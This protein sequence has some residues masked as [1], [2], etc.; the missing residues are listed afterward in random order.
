MPTVT[1]VEQ[2]SIPLYIEI[3]KLH[4]QTIESVG[5]APEDI[6][7]LLSRVK[8]V[9]GYVMRLLTLDNHGDQCLHRLTE[10]IVVRVSQVL[11]Q[12]YQDIGNLVSKHL[13]SAEG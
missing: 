10:G 2:L 11:D 7:L 6:P 9:E 1:T 4:L 8:I 5:F 12:A 13:E 3:V